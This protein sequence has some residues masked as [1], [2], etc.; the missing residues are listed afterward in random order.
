MIASLRVSWIL[1]RKERPFTDS[2]TIKDC[3]LAVVDEIII[4]PKIKDSVASSIKKVPLSDTS[5]L[6]RVDLLAKDVCE[7]LL[8]NLRKAEFMSI[9]VDESTDA[10]DVAQLCIYVRFYDGVCFREELLGLIPLERHTTG[11]VL[12]QNIVAFFD[13]HN[14][15]L[16]KKR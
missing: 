3:M 7:K 4:D 11:E 12:F 6:R 2:E 16:Q 15:D 9:A 13:E 5:T 10:T 14:L 8:D 1:T